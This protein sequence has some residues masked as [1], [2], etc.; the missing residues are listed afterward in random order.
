MGCLRA[1]P[2]ANRSKTICRPPL[3]GVNIDNISCEIKTGVPIDLA[4]CEWDGV[5]GN[6]NGLPFTLNLLVNF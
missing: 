5:F 4:V 1:R 6:F 2:D 3:K